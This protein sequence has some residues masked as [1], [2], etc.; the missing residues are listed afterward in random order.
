MKNKTATMIIC[1]GLL[2]TTISGCGKG[3]SPQSSLPIHE[4]FTEAAERDFIKAIVADDLEAVKRMV[5]DGMDV[6]IKGKYDITPL[7]FAIFDEKKDVYTWL[8]QQGADPWVEKNAP[9]KFCQRYRFFG[10]SVVDHA[11]ND[12][13]PDYL[14]TMLKYDKTGKQGDL[15]Q[16][17]FEMP[18]G[19][20]RHKS[21]QEEQSLQVKAGYCADAVKLEAIL[22]SGKQLPDAPRKLPSYLAESMIDGRSTCALLI[23]NKGAPVTERFLRHVTNKRN[24]FLRASQDLP[25]EAREHHHG[26]DELCAYL[27]S[28]DP[29]IFQKVDKILQEEKSVTQSKDGVGS[30]G[31]EARQKSAAALQ[32]LADELNAKR[33]ITPG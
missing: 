14:L 30:K 17:F 22:D 10:R 6:N 18:S 16:K 21:S 8:L 12:S 32:Q 19:F 3:T 1:L 27:E 28:L 5:A 23:L 13:D 7:F 15:L 4:I 29:E 2:L 26:L 33:G 25:K 31:S 24:A 11:V 9:P 20:Y